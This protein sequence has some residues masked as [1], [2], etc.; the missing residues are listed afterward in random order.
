[1]LCEMQ[2]VSSRIWTR[3]AVSNSYDDNHHTT[4]TS[5]R[6][7]HFKRSAKQIR[8]AGAQNINHGSSNSNTT[9]QLKMVE[10]NI[11]C[12]L[13]EDVKSETSTIGRG[14]KWTRNF[15]IISRST[16]DTAIA[17]WFQ[18]FLSNIN[19]FQTS[20]SPINETYFYNHS[21]SEWTRE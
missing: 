14:P 16:H 7:N 11:I 18:V 4:G 2:S 19:N 17:I 8:P 1:M 9:D 3:V 5:F 21:W 6:K 15:T 20:I 13:Y 12:V 10:S